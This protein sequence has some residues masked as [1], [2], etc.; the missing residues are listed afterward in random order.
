M[1]ATAEVAESE[2]SGAAVFNESNG[3]RRREKGK[4]KGKPKKDERE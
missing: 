1:P 3:Y 2:S 4:D